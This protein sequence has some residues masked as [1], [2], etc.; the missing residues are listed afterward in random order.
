MASFYI[1]LS[2]LQADSTALNTIANNLANLNTTG[3][4]QQ[5]TNFADLFYQQVGTQGSGNPIELGSGVQVSSIQSDFTQGSVVST[6][7][8]GDVAINGNGFFVLGSGG[9]DVYSRDGNF[10]MD[11]KGNLVSQSGLSVMGFPAVAGV[12]NTNAPLSPI[13]IPVGAVEAP[14]PTGSF[15]MTTN[16]D[17]KA[18]VGTVVPGQ[19]KMFDSLGISHVATVT[20]TKTATN[21]WSYSIA[22]PAGEA[23]AAVN[24]TGTLSFSTSGNLTSP[25]ANVTGIG[26]TGLADGAANMNFSWNVLGASGAPTITQVSA[27]SAVSATTQD[28]FASGQYQSFSISPNGTVDVAFSN[29]QTLAVGQLALASVSNLQGMD[30]LGSGNFA[31]TKASGSANVG[32]SGAGGLG[33]LSGASVEASNVDISGE[34]SSLIVAQRAFEA[35]SKAV[36]TFDTIAQETINMIH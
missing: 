2:G 31:E 27:A 8:A 36:T 3:Y 15:G 16:L 10:A 13:N 11:N 18:A 5:T 9:T 28:G 19:V 17:S 12:V 35:N 26:F 23:T 33:T 14:S 30:Q 29:G 24:N 21:A 22:L 20:Y 6:G 34:F 25:S 32:V 1:P 7:N 4:K